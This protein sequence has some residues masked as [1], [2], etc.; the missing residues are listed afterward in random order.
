M[1]E[2]IVKIPRHLD[3]GSIKLVFEDDS[4]VQ[5]AAPAPAQAT[6]PKP[7]PQQAAAP[8]PAAPAP[9]PAPAPAPAPA[10]PAAPAPRGPG[11]PPKAAS[12]PTPTMTAPNKPAAPAPAK[13]EPTLPSALDGLDLG[14]EADAEE[15]VMFDRREKGHR[16]LFGAL[17]TQCRGSADWIRDPNMIEWAKQFLDGVHLKRAVIVKGQNRFTEAFVAEVKSVLCPA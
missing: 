14:Q 17:V 1:K 5:P 3:V 8:A 15:T 13:T 11:R 16:D 7:A 10:A 6:P 4:A 12:A 9:K 2:L